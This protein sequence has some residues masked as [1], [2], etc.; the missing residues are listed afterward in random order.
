MAEEYSLDDFNA[1]FADDESEVESSTNTDDMNTSHD[2]GKKSTKKKLLLA[3]LASLGVIAIAL[4]IGLGISSK[5]STTV[6]SSIEAEVLTLEQCLDMDEYAFYN[7]STWVPTWSPTSPSE[8]EDEDTQGT[9]SFFPLMDNIPSDDKESE[10]TDDLAGIVSLYEDES[11]GEDVRRKL[12]VRKSM[13][14]ESKRVSILLFYLSSSISYVPSHLIYSICK[15]LSMPTAF[16]R[17]MS[18]YNRSMD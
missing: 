2:G 17:T 1:T 9:Y 15:P 14:E 10:D 18:S 11:G 8:D 5:R 16:E 12:R 4:G 6:S 13:K 7:S 3:G